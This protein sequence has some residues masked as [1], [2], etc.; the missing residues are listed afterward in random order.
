METTTSSL[1]SS[2][3]HLPIEEGRAESCLVVV[4]EEGHGSP[5][6]DV[7]WRRACLGDLSET[8]IGGLLMLDNGSLGS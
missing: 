3:C 6:H 5:S 7:R 2:L 4:V 8:S 1:A